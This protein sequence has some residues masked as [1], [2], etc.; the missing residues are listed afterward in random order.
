M[1]GTCLAARGPEASSST[2]IGCYFDDFVHRLLDLDLAD[3]AWQ[4]L[5]HFTVG[6]ALDDERL[7]TLPAYGH[8]PS[9]RV[10]PS[11]RGHFAL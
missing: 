3:H 10:V 9:D 2:G 5:Y 6:G 1:V 4:S 11:R 7:T 8:L